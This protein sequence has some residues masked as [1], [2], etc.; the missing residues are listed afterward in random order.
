MAVHTNWMV[1]VCAGLGAL[2]SLASAADDSPPRSSRPL[3]FGLVKTL[4]DQS[5]AASKVLTQLFA[6]LIKQQTG[7]DAEV[8]V[9][10]DAFDVGGSLHNK[11]Y[12]LGFL[13]GVEFAWAEHEYPDLRPL[14][15]ISKYHAWH[16]RLVVAK[17]NAAADFAALRGKDLAMPQRYRPHCRLFLQKQC[18]RLGAAEP[19]KFFGQI[20]YPSSVEDALDNLLGG[21]AHAAIV[22]NSALEEY[23]DINPGRFARLRVVVESEPFPPSVIAYRTGGIDKATLTRLR[24]GLVNA[25]KS[26]QGREIMVLCGVTAFQN[27]PAN[28]QEQLANIRKAY[29]PPRRSRDHGDRP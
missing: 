7:V 17:G 14:V 16:A 9:A 24:T 15:T 28:L 3:Q 2:A 10:G 12:Q 23:R 4:T 6:A 1:A 13:Y 25:S 26:A 22:D 19:K 29:P 27:V 21:D 18:A 5:N 8:A 20:T 11:K